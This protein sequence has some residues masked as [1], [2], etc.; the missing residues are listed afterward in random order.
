MLG[1]LRTNRHEREER[2]AGTKLC[3]K[4]VKEENLIGCIMSESKNKRFDD[5]LS[6]IQTEI[7]PAFDHWKLIIKN[8]EKF[9]EEQ[10]E[11]KNEQ[12]SS[13]RNQ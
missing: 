7:K 11:I 1:Q 10:K 6:A 12:I 3:S 5:H 13:T 4:E 2:Q 8:L 9:D